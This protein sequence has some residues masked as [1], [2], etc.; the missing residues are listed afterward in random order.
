MAVT[1][2]S[3]ELVERAFHPVTVSG[4]QHATRFGGVTYPSL[5]VALTAWT[6]C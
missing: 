4:Q 2:R 3:L 6:V 5:P 1:T